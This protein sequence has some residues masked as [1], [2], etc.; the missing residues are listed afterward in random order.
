[1]ESQSN[2]FSDA[3]G[4]YAKSIF[5]I[6]VE[7]NIL[8]EIEKNF[9]QVRT[10]LKDSIDFK[11]FVVNPTI[12]KQSRLSIIETISKKFNFNKYFINFLKLINEKGRFFFLEKIIRDFFS[13]VAES[14]GEVTADLIIANEI[15]EIKKEEIKKELSLLYKKDIKL[16]FS[17]DE[18]LISGSILKVGSKMIDNSAKSKFNRILNNI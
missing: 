16:N 8:P 3:T 11:K 7:K 15:S 12:Q 18:S 1:M 9:F 13:I 14:K 5:Q 6:A 10:L 4:R 2:S 17:V